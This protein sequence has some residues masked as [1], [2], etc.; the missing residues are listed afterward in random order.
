VEPLPAS[1]PL[2][3]MPNVILSPHIAGASGRYFEQAT[4]LFAANL[5][6]YL[7]DQPLLNEFDPQ[8][9]Y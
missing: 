7:T 4:A 3:E 6:R 5:Q 8:R 9:G 1:S 2:W